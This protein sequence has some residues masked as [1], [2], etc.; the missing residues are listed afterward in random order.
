MAVRGSFPVLF[1]LH[2]VGFEVGWVILLVLCSLAR[3]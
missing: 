2:F 1:S 3:G